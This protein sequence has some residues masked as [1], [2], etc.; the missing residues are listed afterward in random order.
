MWKYIVGFFIFAGLALYVMSKGGP[1]D[2]GGEHAA[3]EAMHKEAPAEA[4]AAPAVVPAAP[5]AATAPA[6]A[7]P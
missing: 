6:P 5:A 7:K 1:V 4:P 2:L 3:Q